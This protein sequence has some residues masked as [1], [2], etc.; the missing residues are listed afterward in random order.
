MK[1]YFKEFFGELI[2]SILLVL[3][4]LI[5]KNGLVSGILLAFLLIIGETFYSVSLNP[6]VAL[7]HYL[8]GLIN[9][10]QLKLHLFAEVLAA[11]IAF[12]IYDKIFKKKI[13]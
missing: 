5:Y 8:S 9:L 13:I 6:M 1:I 12:L 4:G 11:I 2:G 10:D 7:A 3:S